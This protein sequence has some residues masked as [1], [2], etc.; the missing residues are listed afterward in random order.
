MAF[1]VDVTWYFD[2][3]TESDG[4]RVL[5]GHMQDFESEYDALTYLSDV[6][7][8]YSELDTDARLLYVSVLN[9][10]TKQFTY[11]HEFE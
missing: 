8:R 11:S 10:E 9:T 6:L 3:E 7:A 5:H 1:T 4:S 2:A